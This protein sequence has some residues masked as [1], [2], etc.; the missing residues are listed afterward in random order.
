MYDSKRVL[1]SQ[2][3][4]SQ[5]KNKFYMCIFLNGIIHVYLLDIMHDLL[6]GIICVLQ[7]YSKLFGIV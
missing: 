5:K 2:L 6:V 4:L 3:L 1:T 7:L